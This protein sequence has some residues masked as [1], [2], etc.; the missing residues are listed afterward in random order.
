MYSV[1]HQDASGY[2]TI[3][4]AASVGYRPDGAV[5]ITTPSGEQRSLERAGT[6]Y[7]MNEAGKN[8]AVYRLRGS[9]QAGVRS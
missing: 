3:V 4:A 7:V 5:V 1:K 6:Y 8:V 2:E 9:R